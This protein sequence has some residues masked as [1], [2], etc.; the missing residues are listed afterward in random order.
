MV[1]GS[2]DPSITYPQSLYYSAKACGVSY[3]NQ[4]FNIDPGGWQQADNKFLA[5]LYGLAYERGMPLVVPENDQGPDPG[6]EPPTRSRDEL[7]ATW[8][9]FKDR[10]W[11]GLGRGSAVQVC[12]GWVAVTETDDG[13]LVG[14]DGT[15]I[16]WWEGMQDRPDMHF[17]VVVG[18]DRNPDEE[19]YYVN[20]PIGGWFGVGKDIEYTKEE[21][22]ARMNECQVS[23]HRF[24]TQTFYSSSSAP[25]PLDDPEEVVKHRIAAKIRGDGRV[26]ESRPLWQEWFGP[27]WSGRVITGTPGLEAWIADLEDGVF[28]ERLRHRLQEHGI[29]PLDTVSYMDL[30]V[31]NF[32]HLTA[33]SAEYLEQ[34]GRINEWE[35]LF[36]LHILYERLWVATSH[37]RAIFKDHYL[38][39]HREM[40]PLHAAAEESSSWR[41]EARKIIGEMK[42]YMERYEGLFL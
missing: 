17:I 22:G 21:F 36:S 8:E 33:V 27:E 10:I 28:D 31:Y 13:E 9:D 37:I 35:W 2:I 12:Q 16:T 1:L 32:S 38:S 14:P 6:N 41:S 7:M 23:Q 11:T 39:E 34:E 29:W 24:L 26:Y 3:L 25:D 20:D 42:S 40:D 30:A 15:R 4:S 5:R 18:M 19:R